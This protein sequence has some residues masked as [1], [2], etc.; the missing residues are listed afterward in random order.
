MEQ[1]IIRLLKVTFQNMILSD[2]SVI[3]ETGVVENILSQAELAISPSSK[4]ELVGYLSTL[5]RN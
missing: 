2:L 3:N 5:V 1:A 4:D